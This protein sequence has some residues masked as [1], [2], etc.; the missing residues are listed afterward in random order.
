LKEEKYLKGLVEGYGYD[1]KKRHIVKK[2]CFEITNLSELLIEDIDEY[3]F[4]IR[5]E[6]GK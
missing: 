3:M 6:I 5:K 2:N 4:Y 1:F